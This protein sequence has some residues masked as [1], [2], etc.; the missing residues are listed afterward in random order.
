M[1]ISNLTKVLLIIFLVV[2]LYNLAYSKPYGPTRLIS[3]SYQRAD[4]DSWPKQG[5]T[6]ECKSSVTILGVSACLCE[7]HKPNNGSNY[8]TGSCG[9]VD[10]C[11]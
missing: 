11:S 8:C 9:G 10:S 6:C 2:P 1:Q 7:L 5:E 3:P 4:C